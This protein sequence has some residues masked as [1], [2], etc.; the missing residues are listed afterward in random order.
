MRSFIC[1]PATIL[2][3]GLTCGCETVDPTTGLLRATPVAE[4]SA[5]TEAD[6][7]AKLAADVEA[8]GEEDAAISLYERAVAI[9]GDKPDVYVS[10]GDAQLRAH[11]PAEALRAYR[12]ALD[13]DPNNSAAIFGL[14]SAEV[15]T[16]NADEGIP[17]LVRAA[18]VIKTSNAYNRLGVAQTLAGRLDDARVSYEQALTLAPDDPDVLTNMAFQMALSQQFDAAVETMRKAARSPS[19]KPRHQKN[20]VLVLSLAGRNSEASTAASG[21]ISKPDVRALI[22]RGQA[23]RSIRDVRARARA[24]G[25]VTAN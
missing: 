25:T 22:A 24:L 18:A 1:W 6:R 17:L 8:R 5:G 14:G 20:L 21:D 13:R 11:H 12:A 2:L 9:S 10:L 16:G 7:L 4:A 3:V 23:I 15:G 19:A